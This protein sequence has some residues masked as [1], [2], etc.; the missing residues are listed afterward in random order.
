MPNGPRVILENVCYH[1]VTRGNRKLQVFMEEEDY[2]E[3]LARLS[4]YK[5]RYD[6][7]LY[8]YCLMPNHIHMLGET[9]PAK[10][11]SKFMHG[12][13]RSYTAYYNKKYDKV[14]HLWQGRFRTKIITKDEY[15]IDCINY[16]DLNPVRTM[17]IK[18]PQEYNWSSYNER[19]GNGVVGKLFLDTLPL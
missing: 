9:K 1:I 7:S 2:E 10:N 17:T 13:L 19:T 11:L 3:Y 6:F 15:L 14:G 16:I 12:L 8:G 18:S 4:L 5:K